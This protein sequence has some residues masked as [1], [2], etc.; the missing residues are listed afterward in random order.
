MRTCLCCWVDA[1]SVN[2]SG[3]CQIKNQCYPM[4]ML[5]C[6]ST[7]KINHF[8]NFSFSFYFP[9]LSFSHCKSPKEEV[10]RKSN[11]NLQ[12]SVPHG[13][14]RWQCWEA[15]QTSHVS[16][17]WTSTGDEVHH[18]CLEIVDAFDQKQNCLELQMSVREESQNFTAEANVNV[19]SA[20]RCHWQHSSPMC[21]SI[22]C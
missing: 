10:K 9:S 4:P 14:A 21:W 22:C 18:L 8:P 6:P 12:A 13:S 16:E 5:L 20:M 1:H 11:P 2:D 7:S 19:T 17:Q 3:S 15:S